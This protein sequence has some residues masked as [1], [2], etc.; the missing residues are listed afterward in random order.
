M[1]SQISDSLVSSAMVLAWCCLFNLTSSLPLGRGRTSGYDMS[2]SVLPGRG[3]KQKDAA[4]VHSSR[5]HGASCLYPLQA[6]S[7]SFSELQVLT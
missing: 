4:S 2:H 3:M 6:E 1:Q 7:P 5:L